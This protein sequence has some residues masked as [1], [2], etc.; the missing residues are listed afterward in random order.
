MEKKNGETREMRKEEDQRK[1][2]Q[3]EEKIPEHT[4]GSQNRKLR[5]IKEPKTE[6]EEEIKTILK[7]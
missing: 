6:K 7:I 2:H 3:N 1:T 5:E 4:Q